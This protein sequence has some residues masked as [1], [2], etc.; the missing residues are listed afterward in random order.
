MPRISPRA[1]TISSA[2]RG[3]LRAPQ[4]RPPK[5]TAKTK[6]RVRNGDGPRR[7]FVVLVTVTVS[8]ID[9]VLALRVAGF[10]LTAQV[11]PPGAPMQVKLTGPEK[12]PTPLRVRL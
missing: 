4:S 6:G 5:A 8:G 10:G 7:A 1:R 3:F 11:E 2:L 9:V 12:P